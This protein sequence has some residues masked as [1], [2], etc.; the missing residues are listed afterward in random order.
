MK[1]FNLNKI[2]NTKVSVKISGYHVD[3]LELDSI[4]STCYF[5]FGLSLDNYKK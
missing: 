1:N 2:K 5:F 4:I 3:E